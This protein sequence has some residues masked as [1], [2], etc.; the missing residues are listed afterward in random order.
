[1]PAAFLLYFNTT[2]LFGIVVMVQVVVGVHGQFG[3]RSLGHPFQP[4]HHRFLPGIATVLKADPLAHGLN[5]AAVGNLQRRGFAELFMK[6]V[7]HLVHFQP[8]SGFVDPFK[9]TISGKAIDLMHASVKMSD[10]GDE[11]REM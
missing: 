7:K 10:D 9:K 6:A 8:T 5:A 3:H 4:P 1:M 2:R 11:S